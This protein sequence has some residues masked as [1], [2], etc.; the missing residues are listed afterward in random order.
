MLGVVLDWQTYGFNGRSKSKIAELAVLLDDLLAQSMLMAPVEFIS[1]LLEK[2]GLLNMY[3]NSKDED[4]RER[5]ENLN[6]LVNAATRF[7]DDNPEATI[8][9]YLENIA[10]VS[11]PEKEDLFGEGK[12]SISM[13]TMHS[14][15]G[16]EFRTVFLVGAEEG[17]FPLSR[18]TMVESELEEERR[19]CYVAMT[20]A[21]EQLYIT[22]TCSRMLYGEV[23]AS[24]KS[25]FLEEIP[26]EHC[27]SLLPDPYQR[28]S[29]GNQGDDNTITEPNEA[30][31]R[32]ENRGR[33]NNGR[34]K[35]I[36]SKGILGG[37]MSG[38]T[39]QKPVY[40]GSGKYFPGQ[41]VQHKRFGTGTVISVAGSGDSTQVTVAFE[42]QGVKTLVA[43][44][45]NLE[46]VGE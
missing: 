21:M 45:A 32:R 23:R 41:K 28:S 38:F 5:L 19:L 43:I 8:S 6:E 10:L 37:G 24:A 3:R 7:F 44:Y 42:G 46:N 2:T 15:K 25:R 4:A 11:E 33:T 16:L 26:A 1:Y 29:Y 22:Y 9:D 13:M 35:A 27:E 39:T 34:Q 30:Q 31:V 36:V 14:A 20:R 18:A 17:I 12:G 40:G